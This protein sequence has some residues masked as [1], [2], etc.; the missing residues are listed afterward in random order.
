MRKWLRRELDR[1]S[2]ANLIVWIISILAGLGLALFIFFDSPSTV[3]SETAVEIFR[4]LTEVDGVLI[5]LTG[6][7]G[8]FIIRE[9]PK[10]LRSAIG[11]NIFFVVINLVTST[12][13]SLNGLM[14]VNSVPV[15]LTRFIV[16]IA[17]LFAGIFYLFYVLLYVLTPKR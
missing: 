14:H 3:S 4:V 5:G 9:S 16:P 7:I 6:I 2:P 8:V 12:L 17:I 15:P 10:G 11:S 1:I 13:F